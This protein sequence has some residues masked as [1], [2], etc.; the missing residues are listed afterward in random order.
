MDCNNRVDLW[1]ISVVT[2]MTGERSIA[3]F[4]D[5]IPRMSLCSSSHTHSNK[6]VTGDQYRSGTP[7][8]TVALL[9]MESQS[10]FRHD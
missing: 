8:F 1:I 3:L 6:Q 10:K 4:L 2:S 9:G 7:F 5:T